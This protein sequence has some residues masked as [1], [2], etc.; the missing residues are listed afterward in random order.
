MGGYTSR[1]T[2][3]DFNPRR[4]Q[5]EWWGIARYPL[6]WENECER[7]KTHYY[8]DSS[9]KKMHVT[10]TCLHGGR[11]VRTR[12]GEA[13]VQGPAKFHLKY[14]E[15]GP[16]QPNDIP[17]WVHWT[18]YENFAVVGGPS[19]KYLWILARKSSVSKT[20]ARMLMNIVD[21]FGYDPDKLV[22]NPEAVHQTVNV[23]HMTDEERLTP[24]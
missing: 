7:S 1:E 13:T 22:A 9:E 14:T 11:I 17:Y 23:T 6:P 20:D 16:T 10:N 2:Q 15:G 24:Y 3:P 19:K 21:K 5:G 12:I 18:D 8:W 4:Y